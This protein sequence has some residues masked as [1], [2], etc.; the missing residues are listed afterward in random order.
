MNALDWQDLWSRGMSHEHVLWL[1]CMLQEQTTHAPDSR[2]RMQSMHGCM[3]KRREPHPLIGA[4]IPLQWHIST[5]SCGK[6]LGLWMLWGRPAWS[7]GLKTCRERTRKVPC[8][9]RWMSLL[10]QVSIHPPGAVSVDHSPAL[11]WSCQQQRFAYCT[12]FL[13]PSLTYFLSGDW[14]WNP[15]PHL[16]A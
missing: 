7:A 14:I 12:L 4:Q 9:D 5:K 10:T 8:E 11:M 16:C 2:E 1:E 6:H 3:G 13:C 15:I